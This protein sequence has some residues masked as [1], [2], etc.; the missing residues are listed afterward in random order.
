MQ[1][2]YRPL[3]SFNQQPVNTVELITSRLQLQKRIW[4]GVA[5]DGKVFGFDLEEPLGNDQAFYDCDGSLYIVKQEPEAVYAIDLITL[6]QAAE[7]A[8]MIGNLHFS[9]SFSEKSLIV[10]VDPALQNLF[11]EQ[12][13]SYRE[14][15]MV[16]QP[17][18]N[19]IAHT[20]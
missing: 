11:V 12:S 17:P 1:L 20:H 7:T 8:W 14:E 19:R 15:T 10:P 13:I 3:S 18:K 4:R 16:F 2:I 5:E 6:K 9:A